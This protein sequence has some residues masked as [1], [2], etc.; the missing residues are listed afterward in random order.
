MKM[1]TV[2]LSTLSTLLLATGYAAGAPS[3]ASQD[4]DNVLVG[5]W[6]S[7]VQFKSGALS[8][9]KDL[10][11]L[12]AFNAG[13]TLTESSNYDGAPPVPP[14]YGVWRKIQPRQY[15]A[16]YVFFLSKAPKA[17]GDI[18]AGGGW[19]PGGRGVLIEKITVAEDGQSFTSE[20][21]LDI[22]DASGK[23]IESNSAAEGRAVRITF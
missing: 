7:H 16:K 15:E 22:V 3:A 23:T 1:R 12:Y 21:W 5:A 6:Q 17:F 19:L 18:A 4:A 14:A 2:A 13:G 20:I 9:V 11:L 10:E 8:S